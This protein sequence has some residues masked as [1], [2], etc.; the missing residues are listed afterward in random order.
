[1]SDILCDN[2][3]VESKWPGMEGGLVGASSPATKVAEI[4]IFSRLV[5]FFLKEKKIPPLISY[6]PFPFHSFFNPRSQKKQPKSTP[7]T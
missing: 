5:L 7:Q 3:F 6:S 2:L 1:M 4:I